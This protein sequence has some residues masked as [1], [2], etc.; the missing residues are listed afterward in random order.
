MA[1]N[2]IPNVLQNLDQTRDPIRN[3][4]ITID[5]SFGV[6]HVAYGVI[7]AGKHNK[8]TMPTIAADP[9]ASYDAN[10]VGFFNMVN[11]DT[12]R[13]EIYAV[14]SGNLAYPMTAYKTTGAKGSTYTPSGYIMK[15]G[16]ATVPAGSDPL[17]VTFEGLPWSSILGFSCVTTT[18][19]STY[20]NFCFAQTNS[21]GPAQFHVRVIA[22]TSAP[23]NLATE[24]IDIAWWAIG[25]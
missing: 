1:L 4:F 12:S 2:Y 11:A 19:L 16:R 13:N 3:N 7:G 24:A 22:I 23:V 21:I 10:E 6:D 8:I 9:T 20:G 5:T 25:E 18:A 17:I 14:Q 15:W